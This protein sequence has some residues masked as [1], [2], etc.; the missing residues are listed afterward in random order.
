MDVATLNQ[1][2]ERALECRRRAKTGLNPRYNAQCEMSSFEVPSRQVH[3]DRLPTSRNPKHY[4][5]WLNTLHD[6]ACPNLERMP[7]E[8]IGRPEVMMCLSPIWTVKHET[9]K[10]LVQCAK[11]VLGVS[12]AKGF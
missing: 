6:D 7:V 5:Q 4:Q 8:A 10:R 9:T 2:R 12:K 11:V 1:G 3:I